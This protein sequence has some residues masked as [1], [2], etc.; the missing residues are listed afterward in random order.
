MSNYCKVDG[1]F[2]RPI[3]KSLDFYCVQQTKYRLQGIKV[4]ANGRTQP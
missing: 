3:Y 2:I 1:K 4:D